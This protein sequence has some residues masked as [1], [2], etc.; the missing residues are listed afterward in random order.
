MEHGS[1]KLF[2]GWII[3]GAGFLVMAVSMGIVTNCASLFTK[4]LC[5]D[6]GLSRQGAGWI[7]T[8][9]YAGQMVTSLLSGKIFS[10]FDVRF[11]M[12]ICAVGV[13][14]GWFLYSLASQLWQF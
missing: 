12:K 7:I 6:L 13:S 5:D 4:P 2:Y 10:T 14:L 11:V 9:T 1:K 3:V 8:I